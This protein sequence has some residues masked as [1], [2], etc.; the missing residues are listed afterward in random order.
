MPPKPRQPK[1]EGTASSK[2]HTVSPQVLAK[3][4]N[5][6]TARVQQLAK[7]HIIHRATHGEY[8]L[9]ES[10]TSY[11]KY[12]QRANLGLKHTDASAD[13]TAPPD[14]LD[15]RNPRARVDLAKAQLAEIALARRQGELIPLAALSQLWADMALRVRAKIQNLPHKAAPLLA[16]EK[17]TAPAIRK[18]LETAT[19][20]TLHE[21]ADYAAAAAAGSIENALATLAPC[22]D[23]EISPAAAPDRQPVG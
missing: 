18:I 8:H 14:L 7:E 10:I 3:L 6:T 19:D 17:R 12:L 13:P 4:L 16:G 2:L 5:L 23:G 11:V 15:P 1:P 9:W 20:E 22:S 21:I